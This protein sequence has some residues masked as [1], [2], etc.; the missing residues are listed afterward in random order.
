MGS[1]YSDVTRCAILKAIDEGTDD[2]AYRDGACGDGRSLRLFSLP[3]GSVPFGKA[4][5]RQEWLDDHG[6]RLGTAERHLGAIERCASTIV[7]QHATSTKRAGGTIRDRAVRKKVSRGRHG[8][9]RSVT[10][11]ALRRVEDHKPLRLS[12]LIARRR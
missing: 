2:A 1:P 11:I 7:E 8:C 6:E 9:G 5:Q 10:A 4:G 3:A 12:V